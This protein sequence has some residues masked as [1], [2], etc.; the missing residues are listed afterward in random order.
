MWLDAYNKAEN[1][2]NI[3]GLNTEF[4]T[5]RSRNVSSKADN[6]PSTGITFSPK[7]NLRV[8]F[9][10]SLIDSLISEIDAHFPPEIE[11]FAFLDP[12]NFKAID[13]IIHT[14][15]YNSSCRGMFL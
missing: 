8:N 2:A 10:D 4:C 14:P 15:S 7:A 9:Y 1:F 6:N 3:L 5:P 13:A 12:K 11:K